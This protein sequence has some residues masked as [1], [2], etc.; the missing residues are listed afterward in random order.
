MNLTTQS[1]LNL[2]IKEFK[3]LQTD[4]DSLAFAPKWRVFYSDLSQED[5]K[6]A[7][8]AWFNAISDNL[9]QIRKTVENMSNEEKQV[10][11][12]FFDDIKNHAFFQ[13]NEA[14]VLSV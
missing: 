7:T 4:A 11:V 12:G 9:F 8:N 1:Q 5:A 2:L 6:I 3:T 14:N 10:H 13:K